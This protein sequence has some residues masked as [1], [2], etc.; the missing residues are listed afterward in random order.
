MAKS[1][2]KC[3]CGGTL[4]KPEEL[5]LDPEAVVGDG[6]WVWKLKEALICDKCGGHLL[7]TPEE[8]KQNG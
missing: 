6:G 5:G 8:V 3:D 1:G 4:R 2:D 7:L